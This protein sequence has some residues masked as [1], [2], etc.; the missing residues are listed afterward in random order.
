MSPGLG[1]LT[2]SFSTQKTIPKSKAKKDKM[3]KLSTQWGSEEFSYINVFIMRRLQ[4]IAT[5]T[6]LRQIFLK[7]IF[8]VEY[9]PHVTIKSDHAPIFEGDD[10]T[11]LCQA[12]ANPT[13]MTYRLV[14]ILY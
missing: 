11:F 10:V 12:H 13:E 9:A 8:K 7:Q 3:S 1:L 4:R 6:F 5:Y 14:L 2:K